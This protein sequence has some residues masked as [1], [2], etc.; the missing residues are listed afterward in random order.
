MNAMNMPLLLDRGPLST[1]EDARQLA[2]RYH[3]YNCACREAHV[4][5]TGWSSVAVWAKL[6]RE[7][8]ET[9]GV[10]FFS[11]QYLTAAAESANAEANGDRKA[12]TIALCRMIEE[13]ERRKG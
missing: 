5:Q 3:A 12:A 6:L 11:A 13:Q 1:S 4:T 8:Q 9:T 7:S 2:V 10:E